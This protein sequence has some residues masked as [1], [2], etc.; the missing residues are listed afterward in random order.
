[1]IKEKEKS[2]IYFII[3]II[4]AFIGGMVELYSIFIDQ[5]FTFM[6]TGNL[7]SI[8]IDLYKLNLEIIY[9]LFSLLLFLIFIFIFTLIKEKYLKEHKHSYIKLS[10]ILLI[11]NSL[12]MVFIPRNILI[13]LND[14]T[15]DISRLLSILFNTLF[16]VILLYSFTYFHHILFIPTMMSNNL[17]QAS[18]LLAKALVNKN[19]NN[20]LSKFKTYSIIIIFFILGALTSGGYLTYKDL[21]F[22]NL[23][24]YQRYNQN[25]IYIFIFILLIIAFIL[26]LIDRRYIK[27]DGELIDE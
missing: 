15:L 22:D 9:P 3:F 24:N 17:R 21:I 4:L 13:N 26:Y 14:F 23:F 27:E 10:L 12:I 8:I 7:I 20:E 19:K 6:Q 5:L 11:I 1:M 16:G 2:L 25:L 18:S